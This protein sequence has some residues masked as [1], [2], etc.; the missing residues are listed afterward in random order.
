MN[1]LVISF[2]S[3]DRPGLVD[4]L[5]NIVKKHQGNWQASSLHHLSNTFAG[6]IEISVSEENTSAIVNEIKQIENLEAVSTITQAS[7]EKLQPSIV[8]ELT[9]NDRAGIIQEISST[10]H[11]Q[12]GNLL[13]LVTKQESAAHSGQEL[14]K[15][16]AT[17]TV[18][19]DQAT[20]NL[21]DALENLADDLMVDISR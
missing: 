13:K 10:V 4:T 3:P 1:N 14:F 11:Q 17:I 5:S 16:K 2:V 21:I 7:A 18:S 19:G 6:V 20:D 12:G 9:A 15:A 8:L